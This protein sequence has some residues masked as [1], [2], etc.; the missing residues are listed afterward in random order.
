M[1]LLR[2]EP[3]HDTL[4]VTQETEYCKT[5]STEART[6]LQCW[7]NNV[8]LNDTPSKVWFGFPTVARTT[9]GLNVFSFDEILIWKY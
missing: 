9:S 8:I 6:A 7:L 3:V 5:F 4:P 2:K 1:Q